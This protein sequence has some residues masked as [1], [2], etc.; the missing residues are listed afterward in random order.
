MKCS[1]CGNEIKAGYVNAH[2]TCEDCY[3]E[4]SLSNLNQAQLL[5]IKRLNDKR[6]PLSDIADRIG[7]DVPVVELA[8]KRKRYNL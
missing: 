4:V 5:C 2:A 3:P 7:V 1:I 8:I 6:A